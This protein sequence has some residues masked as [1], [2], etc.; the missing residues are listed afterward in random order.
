MAENDKE[1]DQ[2]GLKK[3]TKHYAEMTKEEQTG[4]KSPEEIVHEGETQLVLFK[5]NE[6]RQVFHEGEWYFSVV[7]VIKAIT[8]SPRPAGYWSDLKRKLVEEEGFSELYDN[9]VKLPLPGADGKNRDTDT[10]N[11]ETLF[12]LVQS[13]PSKKAERFKRWLARVGYER[14]Q[15]WQNPE[16][17]IKRAIVTY[18]AKG[19][20]DEWIN[21][22]VQTIVSR[23]E[24]T[25]EWAKR[26][27]TEGLEYALLT[28]AISVGTFGLKTQA[29]KDLKGLKKHHTL[30]DHMTPLELALTMLGE[31]TTAEIARNTDAQ[32]YKENE[33]AAKAGGEVAGRARKD[34]ERK[35]GK[36]VVSRESFLPDKQKKKLT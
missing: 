4:P 24:L 19:Y 2:N 25:R 16:I 30:R 31:S 7:D 14:I 8:E 6:I 10:A 34:V 28:D 21:Q 13:V 15:E 12:R 1:N 5:G 18:K 9:I 26:G 20:S 17:A 27:V 32:G 35:I 11:I 29:H 33:Q 36:P 22:R 3:A 23:K